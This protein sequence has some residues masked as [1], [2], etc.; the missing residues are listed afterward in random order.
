MSSRSVVVVSDS[1][2]DFSFLVV[3]VIINFVS[4]WENDRLIN[5][6]PNILNVSVSPILVNI[7][8]YFT[9]EE[10][11]VLSENNIMSNYCV[12][13][14]LQL[15]YFIYRFLFFLITPVLFASS[16]FCQSCL[17]SCFVFLE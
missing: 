2:R 1:P 4:N 11:V 17:N 5:F 6:C 9:L 3:I 8:F 7:Y 15:E 13:Y 14:C 12:C 10:F 16:T